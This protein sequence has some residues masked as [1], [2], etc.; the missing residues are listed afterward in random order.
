MLEMRVVEGC[1]GGEGCGGLWR[2]EG[3][4]EV[5][6]GEGCVGGECCVGGEGGGGL[7]GVRVAA[8]V[9]EVRVVGR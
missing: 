5:R 4:G 3:C 8:V 2:G 6:V 7:W 1:G 9:L